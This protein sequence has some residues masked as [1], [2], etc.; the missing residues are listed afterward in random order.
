MVKLLM[1]LSL[2][3]S[4]AIGAININKANSAQLQRLYGIGPTKA[5]EIIKYRKAHNGFR[6]V[7][8]LVNVKGI[9]AKTVIKIKPQVTVR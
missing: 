7:D 2:F 8:E 6:S 1:L 5:Q 3:F 4:F 9:G